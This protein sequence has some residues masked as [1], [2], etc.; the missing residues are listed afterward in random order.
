MFIEFINTVFA[1]CA[2]DMEK[3]FVMVIVI[4]LLELVGEMISALIGGARR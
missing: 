3:F 1:G 2:S 4:F